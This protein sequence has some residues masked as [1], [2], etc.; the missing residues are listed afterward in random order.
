MVEKVRRKI[1]SNSMSFCLRRDLTQ[2]FE[3]PAAKI[4]VIVRPAQDAEAANLFAPDAPGLSPDEID[5]RIARWGLFEA[6]IP[7]CYVAIDQNGVPC[8]AQ[9]LMSSADNDRIQ[10][11]F[12]GVFPILAPDEA[13]LEGAFTPESHRGQGIMPRAMALIAERASDF[14]ARY[15]ITFVGEGNIPS[16]K[17][18]QRSGFAPYRIRKAQ[19]RLLR[20]QVS[21]LPLSEGKPYP[22]KSA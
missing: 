11:F 3:A 20:P 7:R 15:V 2:A 16:L 13:L 10:E 17:G 6:G 18:C 19:W 21:F 4:P 1:Y 14:G 8:Y 5:D 9:W 12:G 22:L